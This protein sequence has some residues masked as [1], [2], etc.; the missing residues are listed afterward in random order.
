[1]GECGSSD[2][3]GIDVHTWPLAHSSL[4]RS[5][6]YAVAPP[7]MA[8]APMAVQNHHRFQTGAGASA[9]G[10]GSPAERTR[11]GAVD[12]PFAL[13]EGGGTAAMLVTARRGRSKRSRAVEPGAT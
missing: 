10:S 7:A 3:H 1:M 11:V 6:R 5:S 9:D 4:G 12:A 13:S 8:T 2:F